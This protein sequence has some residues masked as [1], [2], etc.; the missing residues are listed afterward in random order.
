MAIQLLHNDIR[1]YG[2]T[3]LSDPAHWNGGTLTLV[4]CATFPSTRAGALTLL[5]SGGKRVSNEIALVASEVLLG[6]RAGGGR[7]VVIAPKTGTVAAVTTGQDLYYALCDGARLLVVWD[8]PTDQILSVV[9][10]KLDIPALKVG[11][12]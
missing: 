6:D 3:Q 10:N 1:D 9:G 7:E 11:F 2:L 4:V 8:E 12:P 5:S